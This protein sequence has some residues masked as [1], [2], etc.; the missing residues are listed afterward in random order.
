MSIKIME[1]VKIAGLVTLVV[2]VLLT[3]II[4]LTCVGKNNDQNWQILQFPNGTVKIIV[5][6]GWYM[7]WFGNVW[8]YP[9]SIQKYFSLAKDEGGSKDESIRGTFNDGGTAHFSTMVRF[10]TPVALENK[11]KAHQDFSG[12]DEIMI[13]SV[14]A[15]LVN[16]IKNTAPLMSA[17]EHQSA[18]KAEFTELVHRQLS[19]GLYDMRRVE[20]E[21]KDRT[22]E[23]GQAITV[24]GTEIVK[25][26]KGMPIIASESPLKQYGLTVQQFSITGTEYDPQ[27]L[28]QFIAKKESYLL[29]EKSKAQRE[30]E[31]QERLMIEEKGRKE[32]VEIEIAANKEKTAAT[33]AGEK[34]RDVAELAAEL[35]VMVAV[36]EM[37]EQEAL[38]KKA[39]I[40][41]TREQEV[42]VIRLEAAKLEAQATIELA[43]ATAKKIELAGMITE[44]EQILATIAKDERIGVAEAYSKVNVPQYIITGGEGGG[45]DPIRLFGIKMLQDIS[46]KSVAVP[47]PVK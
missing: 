44:R 33:I 18:R 20:K 16:C 25:D 12:S 21:L 31:V 45:A 13:Q 29:A 2:T 34:E 38:K 14:K 24:L 43:Q 46:G 8:T 30:Q 9:K 23:K 3:V 5:D 10:Q 35:K 1:K 32:I 19:D 17:T 47:E 22:D 4:A 41:A 26:E 39:V 6:P 7:K 27:I 15:H 40:E 37:A 36:Q 11:R 28:A 42:S